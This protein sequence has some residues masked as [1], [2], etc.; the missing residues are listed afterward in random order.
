MSETILYA[1]GNFPKIYIYW[2]YII[3]IYI[4][5]KDSDF[6]K[7][8]GNYSLYTYILLLYSWKNVVNAWLA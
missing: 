2:E 4:H 7:N 3:G 6:G 8:N 5:R 1:V